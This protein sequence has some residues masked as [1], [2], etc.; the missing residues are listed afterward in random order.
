[1]E[2]NCFQHRNVGMELQVEKVDTGGSPFVQICFIRIWG[3]PKLFSKLHSY[4]SCGKLHAKI[5]IHLSKYFN[6]LFVQIK[7]DP[8]VTLGTDK[9]YFRQILEG[10]GDERLDGQPLRKWM[11]YFAS[12]TERQ[13]YSSRDCWNWTA[14]WKSWNMTETG[15]RQRTQNSWTKPQEP[16][17]PWTRISRLLYQ[18]LKSLH[19]FKVSRLALFCVL[20]LFHV[21]L[22]QFFLGFL[23]D[24]WLQLSLVEL[25]FFNAKRWRSFF[26]LFWAWDYLG[27]YFYAADRWQILIAIS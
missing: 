19:I 18:S 9:L 8:P 16:L 23:S 13:E 21:C 10:W 17:N 1:M 27:R 3:L 5:E 14:L 7:R 12:S 26:L 24:S 11:G 20:L 25:L 2:W 15:W 22:G 4:S 6:L